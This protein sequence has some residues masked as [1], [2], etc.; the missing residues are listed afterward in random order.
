MARKILL[1]DFGEDTQMR[2]DDGVAAGISI[3][4]HA[5][6]LQ[7]GAGGTSNCAVSKVQ[8]NFGKLYCRAKYV[9]GTGGVDFGIGMKL[10]GATSGVGNRPGYNASSWAVR[11]GNSVA[12]N[13]QMVHSGVGTNVTH[14]VAGDYIDMAADLN[15]GKVWFGKGTKTSVTWF[16]GNPATGTSPAYSDLLA[17]YDATTWGLV[18]GLYVLTACPNGANGM[19]EIVPDFERCQATCPAG[20]TP[21]GI[22]YRCSNEDYVSSHA[23]DPADFY[24][25][26]R[27][28]D[29]PDYMRGTTV[30]SW[31]SG[32]NAAPPLDAVTV[33]N[34]DGALDFLLEYDMRDLQVRA[35]LGYDFQALS[36]F[37]DVG[38]TVVENLAIPSEQQLQLVFRDK[39]A[40][41]DKPLQPTKWPAGMPVAEL[42][43]KAKPLAMGSLKWVP[44]TVVDAVNLEYAFTDAPWT[45]TTAILDQGVTITDATGYSAARRADTYGVHRTTN[46]AGKQVAQIDGRSKRTT[47]WQEN[48]T[49][50]SG[51]NPVGWTILTGAETATL[52][53]TQVGS[54]MRC[55]SDGTATLTIQRTAGGSSAALTYTI[56]I[57]VSSYTSGSCTVQAGGQRLALLDRAG[58]YRLSFR[59]NASATFRVVM[60]AGTTCDLAISSILVE[61]AVLIQRLPD[62]LTELCI[63]QTVDFVAAD[64]DSAGTITDL[65]TA[66]TYT[67]ALYTDDSSMTVRQALTATLDSYGGGYFF[68][69]AGQ[70]KVGRLIDPSTGTSVLTLDDTNLQGRVDVVMDAAPGLSDT[71]AGQKN[72]APHTTTDIAGSILNTALGAQL[73]QEFLAVRKTTAAFANAYRHA[74]GAEQIETLLSNAAQVQSE[75]NRF[76]ALYT[77]VRWF[78]T[79][80]AFLEDVAAYSLEPFQVIT[81]KTDRYNLTS[82]FGIG[83]K[84]L[85]V[86]VRSRFLSNLVQI[87]AWG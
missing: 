47:F 74:R 61:T 30:F 49:S 66:T 76:G 64:L 10:G 39:S 79:F 75:A 44:L 60:S 71:W 68:D 45:R 6:M 12:A 50:W 80:N 24:W 70:L 32:G 17:A 34:P 23:D 69:R 41:L 73:Q 11:T 84:L 67:L 87:V 55:Q 42:E 9:Q 36:T 52:R 31:S 82:Q 56:T 86:S 46:P 63:T 25:P 38:N 77:V 8:R 4:Q 35:R 22:A 7:S 43:A 58:T 85:V 29:D 53:F 40:L 33:D 19:L 48:F 16:T 51:D 15:A 72:Y 18:G 2:L 1:L 13:S 14:L 3:F 62:W 20:F 21:W 5:R 37:V 27:I 59:A 65:D 28:V 57:V 78:Y 26:A 83:T 54:T 81:V